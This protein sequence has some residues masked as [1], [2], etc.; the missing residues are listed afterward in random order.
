MFYAHPLWLACLLHVSTRATAVAVEQQP[1]GTQES[2]NVQV[3]R[4]EYVLTSMLGV[5][6]V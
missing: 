1:L 6:R 2:R 4:E 5:Q 3:V